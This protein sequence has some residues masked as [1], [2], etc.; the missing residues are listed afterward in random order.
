MKRIC[1]FLTIPVSL[2]DTP[3]LSIQSKWVLLAIDSICGQ[4][5][6]IGIGL[7]GIASL[8]NL[9]QK[10]VRSALTELHEHGA[11]EVSMRDGHKLMRPL[12]YKDSYPK[13]G[14]KSTIGDKPTDSNPIDYAYIQE[15]WNTICTSLPKLERMTPSRKSRIRSVLKQADLSVEDFIKCFKIIAC[16]PFLSG[17]TDQFRAGFD[18]L[19][20]SSKNATKVWEGFYSRTYQ[21]K[22]DHELIRNGGEVYQ[23]SNNTDTDFYR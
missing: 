19:T 7:Q 2:F 23:Q 10:E 9:S 15:Q 5:E 18:W 14:T 16:T 20:S 17:Q 1:K 6:W 13:I 12:L 4:G 11:I 21:E 8:T 22:R 3:D